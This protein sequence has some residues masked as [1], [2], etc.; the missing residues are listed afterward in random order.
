[1]KKITFK[2]YEL[3]PE[4]KGKKNKPTVDA[5]FSISSIMALTSARG[6]GK[7]PK[8][9]I[10]GY[11][12]PLTLPEQSFEDTK[13]K[14]IK[15]SES[16]VLNGDIFFPIGNYVLVNRKWVKNVKKISGEI[17]LKDNQ[18]LKGL[19]EDQLTG[20]E[21]R[22]AIVDYK[23]KEY[24]LKLGQDL[25]NNILKWYNDETEKHTSKFIS[26]LKPLDD[27]MAANGCLLVINIVMS[28]IVIVMIFIL[29]C[30]L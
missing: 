25:G 7:Y 3:T 30:K 23:L 17:V 27:Q 8:L 15:E 29:L 24:N 2:T 6:S 10:D 5:D 1:M 18:V 28:I 11:S 9:Y 21:S 20:Y 22:S 13:N 16:E 14:I 4:S 26:A 19:K 12:E